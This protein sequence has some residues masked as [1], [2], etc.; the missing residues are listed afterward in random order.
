[1]NNKRKTSPSAGKGPLI[2][3]GILVTAPSTAECCERCCS[4][5]QPRPLLRRAPDAAAAARSGCCCDAHR[6]LLRR[7]PAA[8]V[9]CTGYCCVTPQP[10]VC[11]CFPPGTYCQTPQCRL[12]K[13]RPLDYIYCTVCLWF[14]RRG[15]WLVVAIALCGSDKCGDS[16]LGCANSIRDPTGM[17]D[18]G[19]FHQEEKTRGSWKD[20]RG[21]SIGMDMWNI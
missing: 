12:V 14:H 15:A 1:M 11:L 6:L 20:E 4:A 19:I 21:R 9:T 7:A 16:S 10:L 3:N 2:G 18:S 13:R 17:F 8:A 5:T